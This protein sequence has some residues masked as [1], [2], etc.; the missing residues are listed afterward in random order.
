MR[1]AT[2]S[3]LSNLVIVL[4]TAGMAHA[5]DSPRQLPDRP[6]GELYRIE[7]LGAYWPTRANVIVSSDAPGLPGTRIDFKRDLGLTDRS[8]PELQVTWRP[9]LRHKFRAQYIPIHFDATATPSRSLLFNGVPYPGGLPVSSSLD[10][11]T[12][13]FG[14]AYDFIVT[15]RGSVG[16]VTEVKHTVVRAALRAGLAD[17][18]S[19]QAMPVPAVG[20]VVRVYPAP[21]LALTGEVTFF[22]VPDSDD[23][24]F[25][26]RIADVDLSATWNFSRHVGAQAGFRDIDIHHLGEWNTAT[27]S[28]KGAYVGVV[29]RN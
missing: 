27:F 13:R 16:V 10:W 11:T 20:G 7:A 8:F 21:R 26:G 12:Y 19:R 25:G 4:L 17:E 24:H 28:L 29:V 5:Q 23:G 6:T 15:R 2:S 18:V 9:G 22:G 14:Y 1:H 3:A